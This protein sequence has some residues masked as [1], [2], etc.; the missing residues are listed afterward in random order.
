M[1]LWRTVRYGPLKP[2]FLGA[3]A[4]DCLNPNSAQI[5]FWSRVAISLP[6]YRYGIQVDGKKKD[7]EHQP[8]E[9]QF[10][11]CTHYQQTFV[12]KFHTNPPIVCE[13][14]DIQ[15]LVARM[16][17]YALVFEGGRDFHALY[18][19]DPNPDHWYLDMSS[20]DSLKPAPKPM[21]IHET[22]NN[23]EWAD[24]PKFREEIAPKHFN[25]EEL[26]FFEHCHNTFE[27]HSTDWD[28]ELEQGRITQEQY[29]EVDNLRNEKYKSLA[30]LWDLDETKVSDDTFDRLL[31]KMIMDESELSQ[32]YEVTDLTVDFSPSEIGMMGCRNSAKGGLT[33]QA[34]A[35]DTKA[36]TNYQATIE[37][38]KLIEEGQT[39]GVCKIRPHTM[40]P[41]DERNKPGK[42]E[43][44][45]N[46]LDH[47]YQKIDLLFNG[48]V[49]D[50]RLQQLQ[51]G[52]ITGVSCNG[53]GLDEC[54]RTCFG[55]ASGK[56]RLTDEE[57]REIKCIQSDFAS[58][59]MRL[60]KTPLLLMVVAR[61]GRFGNGIYTSTVEFNKG[62]G[63]VL[64]TNAERKLLPDLR[65]GG[66]N[67]AW[68]G[69]PMQISGE[70]WTLTNNC[71]MHGAMVFCAQMEYQSSID[72]YHPSLASRL[73]ATPKVGD[74]GIYL[75]EPFTE[76]VLKTLEKVSPVKFEVEKR[77]YL[78][79]EIKDAK[80]NPERE[81]VDFCKQNFVL[82][83]KQGEQYIT[84]Q[85]HF[86]NLYKVCRGNRS[87]YHPGAAIA[88]ARS[89]TANCYGNDRYYAFLKEFHD[90]LVSKF[91]EMGYGEYEDRELT[92][93]DGTVKCSRFP[94]K[95]EVR[96]QLYA[97]DLEK[98][99]TLL[100]S[101]YN[102]Y[103]YGCPV[104]GVSKGNHL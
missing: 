12:I 48:N 35:R 87:T 90:K 67:V 24:V 91:G 54:V 81:G 41:K 57:L 102:H 9:R 84:L 58:F 93:I 65:P 95:S 30:S 79:S 83:G 80:H 16:S 72:M 60:W 82:E 78:I 56:G 53:R 44:M 86:K 32:N 43:K 85:R 2:S 27:I 3:K 68:T 98:I 62:A 39:T 96:E 45:F 100:R 63:V 33:V 36:S 22:K 13:F 26:N 42:K 8:Y 11:R 64:C 38:L 37:A 29:D 99:H 92:G 50:R 76:G 94:T 6:D 61:V 75:D 20:S 88:A 59:E 14:K 1:V 23:P 89:Q 25:A 77:G 19:H 73:T 17:K 15:E 55:I 74:D 103:A 71:I 4:I 47:A 52:N 101:L 104:T 51:S 49:G 5:L 97:R 34:A 21:H 7:C 28:A 40:N 46:M 10:C 70:P 18:K 31:A 69:P 66:L